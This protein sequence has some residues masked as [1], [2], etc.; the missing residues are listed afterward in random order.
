MS[1]TQRVLEELS[2]KNPG[3]KE[4][5]LRQPQSVLESSPLS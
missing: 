2:S 3:E 4:F 5:H 1:Y